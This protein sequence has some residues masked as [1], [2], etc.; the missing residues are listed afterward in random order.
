MDGEAPIV[1]S[2][3]S[4][5]K[6]DREEYFDERKLLIEARQGAYLRTDQMVI[7]G[8]TGGL[9]LSIAFLEK[10]A[11]APTVTRPSLLALSWL[12]LLGCL[13][14]RLA[15]QYFTARS[16]DCEIERLNARQND[17]REPPNH[18]AARR[19]GS[20]VAGSILLVIGIG[21]LAIF[22]YLNAPFQ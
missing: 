13:S 2:T 20:A 9:L 5:D 18:W 12:M 1:L 19:R 10:I 8:A 3:E 6:L 7:G 17:E 16:F 15:G 4:S 22:A 14:A 11:P 21:L